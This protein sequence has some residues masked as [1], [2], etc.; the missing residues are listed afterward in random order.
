ML[1]RAILER[2]HEPPEIREQQP[3]GMPF[4]APD[5]MQFGGFGG[6]G[7][8]PYAAAQMAAQYFGAMP[9]R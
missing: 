5:Q 8:D 9:F 7:V 4:F 2:R 3:P 1:Q 6:G